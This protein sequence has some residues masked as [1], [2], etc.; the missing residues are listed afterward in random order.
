MLYGPA[1]ERFYSVDGKNKIYE[2]YEKSWYLNGEPHR[3]DGPA[4]QHMNGDK[5]W[6]YKGILHGRN[7]DFDKK[8][9]KQFVKL[10]IFK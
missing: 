7:K 6:Y 1:I 4:F 8:S 10:L 2:I 3:E 5:W 9:W